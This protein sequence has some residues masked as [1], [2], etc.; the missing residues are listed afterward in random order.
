MGPRGRDAWAFSVAGFRGASR[1]RTVRGLDASWAR[2]S[3]YSPRPGKAAD[4]KKGAQALR[5]K[6]GIKGQFTPPPT[7][8]TNDFVQKPF[9]VW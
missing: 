2:G 3:R 9:V 4:K 6:A 1:P 5:V 8:S 7:P